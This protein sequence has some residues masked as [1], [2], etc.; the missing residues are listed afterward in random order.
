MRRAFT[1]ALMPFVVACDQGSLGVAQAWI[2]TAGRSQLLARQPD[3]PFADAG[4]TEAD[5]RVDTDQ[6]YQAMAGFG[7]AITDAAAHVIGTVLPASSRDSLLQDLFGP[8]GL[9]LGL[10]R[11]TIGA[12]DFSVEPYTLDDVAGSGTD[13]ELRA[14]DP[15]G[16]APML[17]VVRRARAVNPALIVMATPWSAPAWMKEPRTLNGGTL[18]P[19]AYASF[20]TYLHR[21]VKAFDS[22]GVPVALLSLQ[23]EPHHEPPDYPGMRLAPAQRAELIARHVGPLFA[24]EHPNTALLEWD[25]NWDEPASPLAVLADTAARRYIAG[26]AW[27][28]YAGEVNA[29]ATVHA[30]HPDKDAWFTECS[31]GEWAANWGDNLLWN[32]RHLVIGTTRAWARGVLLWN[33]ALDERHGPHRGGCADCRGVVTVNAQTRAVT[34]NEEY[35]ALAHASRF[36]RLGAVRVASTSRDTTV[37]HVAFRNPD[38]GRVL[39]VLNDSPFPRSLD[40]GDGDRSVVVALPA[41]SVATITWRE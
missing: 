7:A 22:A 37:A 34:R 17:D 39:I 35:Y 20:A 33:L 5:I 28:C 8:D 38:E 6:R 32:T 29:Q 10:T 14:F 2:T 40:I 26:V 4:T 30:S 25:H 1:I 21:A 18:R 27:H 31:G 16:A 19:D 3:I 11:V 41:R 36:V 23:N 24:R 15:M 12:S 9:A 13:P